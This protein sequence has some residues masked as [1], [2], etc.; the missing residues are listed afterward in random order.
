MIVP[1]GLLRTA[2]WIL[3]V[4]STSLNTAATRLSPSAVPQCAGVTFNASYLAQV[5]PSEGPGFLLI[6]T[7]NTNQAIKLAKPFPSSAH[8]YAQTGTGPWLW[9]ASSG[10]GGALVNALEE[11]GPLLVY[12][13]PAAASG[14]ENLT[15]QA[16]QHLEL[17]E[18]MQASPI[19][20][21]RPDCERCKN[22]K[23]ERYRAVL[24]YAYR[25]NTG[26]MEKGLLPCGLRSGPIIMPPLE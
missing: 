7:N 6:I 2:A 11:H 13:A 19:L 25:P 4:L 5:S 16:H 22:P 3:F 17:A 9:R 24:A 8:W 10:S 15:V 1:C 14:T 26:S 23:D 12:A 20:R 18:S 21:Y